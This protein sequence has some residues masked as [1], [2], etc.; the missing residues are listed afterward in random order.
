[1]STIDHLTMKAVSTFALSFLLLALFSTDLPAQ[2][3]RADKRFER[4][5]YAPAAK[6]YNRV[7]EK[8][9]TDVESME[10]LAYC[11]RMNNDSRNAE[12]WY[13][14]AI[15]AGPGDPRVYFYYAEALMNNEKW[16]DAKPWLE[17]YLVDRSWDKV[18]INR[19]A[20]VANKDKFMLDSARYE[21]LPTN[22]NTPEAEFSPVVYRNSLVFA[23]TRK[24]T[25]N[26][27]N[28]TGSSFMDLYE[29][30]YNGK[31]ELG[32]PTALQGFA[33]SK[34]HDGVTTFSPEGNVMYF[35]RNDY[36]K[37]RLDKDENGLVRLKTYRAELV[38]GKWK[39]I[40][41]FDFNDANHSVGHP[42]LS[43]D[44]NTMY[45]VSDMVG[46]AG[47]TDIY[48]VTKVDS[49]WTTPVNLG[50]NINTQGNE[51]FPWVSP[52]GVLYFAS[53]GHEG[54]G[55]LDIYQV[56]SMG[57]QFELVE[58][59][60]YPVNTSRDDFG[61]VIDEESGLG[62]FSSDRPG[63]AGK[64]DIYSFRQKQV[65]EGIVID[66]ETGDSIPNAK[67]EI[68]D[69]KGLMTTLRTDDNGRFRTGV[70]RN[71]DL[72]MNASA[73]NYQ[74]SRMPIS[75]VN[76][77]PSVPIDIVM[78][79]ERDLSSPMYTLDGQVRNQA[80]EMMDN[81][82]VRIIAQEVVT[83][84]DANGEVKYSLAADTDY[85]IR[86]EKP[87]FVDAVYSVTTKDM[88]PGDVPMEAVLAKLSMDTA[89]YDIFYDYDKSY[90]RSRSYKELDR[91]VSYL[92]RNPTVRLRLVS[93]ADARGTRGYNNALSKERTFSAYEY[94]VR[95]G[96]SEDRLEQ[97]W[98]GESKPKNDCI[99]GKDCPE[100]DHQANRL[101]EIQYAGEIEAVN[102]TPD[103]EIELENVEELPLGKETIKERE[104]QEETSGKDLIKEREGQ[105]EVT[106]KDAIKERDPETE[107]SI[108]APE[109]IEMP[110]EN[111]RRAAPEEETPEDAPAEEEVDAI[112]LPLESAPEPTPVEEPKPDTPAEESSEEMA[113]VD[114]APADEST[115]TDTSLEL[116]PVEEVP[117]EE[118]PVEE[119]PVEAAP[120][121]TKDMQGTID[122][123]MDEINEEKEDSS[124]DN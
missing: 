85:E 75:S 119:V 41:E 13:N 118:A 71:R 120:V 91:V 78:K 28:W 80:G 57:S 34:Y 44:G 52:S 112:E 110:M 103:A 38:R 10:R 58:N 9:P 95:E 67:I 106:G 108:E 40:T 79:L 65:L 88:P 43:A 59:M 23:S 16:E 68:Y 6:L 116:V 47:G 73:E 55:G 5:D 97:V 104:G 74:E 4:M 37:G 50:E 46:G 84:T 81:A 20:S 96:I 62:F 114:A 99:D 22:I 102:E 27:F 45:F 3:K 92:N 117:I 12:Y 98:V 121:D 36:H 86:V 32:E 14:R 1:M 8:T 123:A 76:F 105:E 11:Y 60:G 69:I 63:G 56:T 15:K 25:K 93:H 2:K 89:L 77:E 49:G 26:I 51:M 94:L 21:I 61:L 70:D 90:L 122:R 35:T 33:N 100:E 124:D 30:Q 66:E 24:T 48:K 54:L 101:T 42:C 17:K 18:A 83:S 87:G 7:L 107:K 53:N 82:T 31:P 19:L 39:R 72:M 111:E 64:D 115:E 113:P 29:V 109:V